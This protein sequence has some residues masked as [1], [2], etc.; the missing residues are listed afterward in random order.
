[1]LFILQAS[2]IFG[3][4]RTMLKSNLQFYS[5]KMYFNQLSDVSII[6]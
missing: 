3:D 1:M 2:S 5:L 4:A 6:H